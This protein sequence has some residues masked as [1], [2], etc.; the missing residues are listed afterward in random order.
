MVLWDAYPLDFSTCCNVLT[1]NVFFK[2]LVE[3]FNSSQMSDQSSIVRDMP[4]LHL[5][6][7]K[8]ALALSEF[9][10]KRTIHESAINSP[11]GKKFNVIG[12]W[13]VERRKETRAIISSDE[14]DLLTMQQAKLSML[15]EYAAQVV[16]NTVASN[17]P[18]ALMAI[19]A[20][21][22]VGGWT[23]E[24][25]RNFND[26]GGAPCPREFIMRRQE[27]LKTDDI[28]VGREHPKAND[29]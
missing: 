3:I 9:F 4:S 27:R 10:D 23:G 17:P 22:A 28:G 7:N 11:N 12:R 1:E 19:I 15:E 16:A 20:P 26:G 13:C 14:M 24:K 5:V 29:E 25:D 18:K 21:N 6:S 8:E 2:S